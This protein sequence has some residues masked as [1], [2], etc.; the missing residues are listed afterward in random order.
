MA[1]GVQGAACRLRLG[2]VSLRAGMAGQ[3]FREGEFAPSEAFPSCRAV[4]RRL[5]FAC[6]AGIGVGDAASRCPNGQEGASGVSIMAA[7]GDTDVGN[8]EPQAAPDGR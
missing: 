1:F 2:K 5:R 3:S 8:Q 6:R 4:L 7:E